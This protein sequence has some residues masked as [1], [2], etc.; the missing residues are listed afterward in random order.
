MDMEG[1]NIWLLILNRETSS[2]R[3]RFIDNS[4]RAFGTEWILA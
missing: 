3:E 2:C 1:K 4:G